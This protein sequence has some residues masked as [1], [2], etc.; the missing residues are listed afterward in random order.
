MPDHTDPIE[1]LL[2]VTLAKLQGFDPL[3]RKWF[4]ESLLDDLGCVYGIGDADDPVRAIRDVG[5][6]Y[7]EAVAAAVRQDTEHAALAYEAAHGVLV[8]LLEVVRE[9]LHAPQAGQARCYSSGWSPGN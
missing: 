2:D 5:E 8:G 1:T 7:I 9:A 6:G 4:A 3:D